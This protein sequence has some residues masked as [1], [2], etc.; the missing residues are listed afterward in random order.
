MAHPARSG[1]VAWACVNN[2]KVACMSMAAFTS[3]PLAYLDCLPVKELIAI[4]REQQQQRRMDI[5]YEE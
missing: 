1:L 2:S 3:T 4:E 5:V